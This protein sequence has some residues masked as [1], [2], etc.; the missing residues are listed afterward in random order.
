MSLPPSAPPGALEP[1]IILPNGMVGYPEW[2]H[3]VLLT[4]DEEDL[5][6]AV[7]QSLDDPNVVFMV[8]DPRMLVTEYRPSMTAHEQQL[9]ELDGAEP[10]LYCTLTV[11]EDGWLTANLLGPLA[12]NPRT[13]RGLQLVLPPDTPYT[14]KH[15]ITRMPGPEEAEPCSS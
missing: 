15:R 11:G 5:P 2:K 4:D 10:V 3:F 9:L 7:L 12:I 14:T 6:V 13:G 1:S 8:T